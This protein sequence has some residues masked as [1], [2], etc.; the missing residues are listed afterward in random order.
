MALYASS[1]DM[2]R[3]LGG[4]NGVQ[5]ALPELR[6]NAVV[7]RAIALVLSRSPILVLNLAQLEGSA[8]HG[9]GSVRRPRMLPQVAAWCRADAVAA[10][11]LEFD[12]ELVR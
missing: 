11:W 3:V 1:G 12:P 2:Q 5:V 4:M 7:I 6:A 8:Q 10:G 9:Q